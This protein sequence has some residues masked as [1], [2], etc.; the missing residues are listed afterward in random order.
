[1]FFQR[2]GDFSMDFD[3][4]PKI[5]EKS[6]KPRINENLYALKIVKLKKNLETNSFENG[7]TSSMVSLTVTSRQRLIF[8]PIYGLAFSHG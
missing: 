1:M 6:N 4:S 2:L 8:M 7:P 3:H 5:P